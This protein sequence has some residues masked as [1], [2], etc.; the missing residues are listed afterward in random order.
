MI[1][2]ELFRFINII[3]H[4]ISLLSTTLNAIVNKKTI[5]EKTEEYALQNKW[6][7]PLIVFVRIMQYY[8]VWCQLLLLVSLYYD[9]KELVVIVHV[10]MT[11]L[12]LLYHSIRIF[13][14]I[15]NLTYIENFPNVS[16]LKNVT[17]WKIPKNRAELIVWSIQNIQHLLGPLYYWI[18]GHFY[19]SIEHDNMLLFEIN[20]IYFVYGLFNFFCWYVNG[21]P[22][23]PIQKKVYDK[24]LLYAILFYTGCQCLL[25]I[26][27][28]L[29]EYVFGM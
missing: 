16:F 24:G 9:K 13:F 27:V 7:I 20:V 21:I 17:S 28:I 8:T 26:S 14:G 5:H 12:F 4:T 23:Y 25:N 29:C 15:L 18:E 11:N 19:G 2:L 10:L 1:S 22:T 3:I 6:S